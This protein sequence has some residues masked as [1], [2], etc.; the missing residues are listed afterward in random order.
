MTISD[1]LYEKAQQYHLD[2]YITQEKI[3]KLGVILA[4]KFGAKPLIKPLVKKLNLVEDRIVEEFEMLPINEQVHALLTAVYNNKRV[5]F[6][7]LF[8]TTGVGCA[9]SY[10]IKNPKFRQGRRSRRRDTI[11]DYCKPNMS[12]QQFIDQMSQKHNLSIKAAAKKRRDQEN[13]K[14]E[15]VNDQKEATPGI[16]S[17]QNLRDDKK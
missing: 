14:I 5:V 7:G 3:K 1:Y 13:E 2:K 4:V 8:L 15:E 11:I 12:E 16:N 9:A 17:Q 6:L 10:Y